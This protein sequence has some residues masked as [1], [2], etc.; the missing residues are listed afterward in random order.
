MLTQHVPEGTKL[1]FPDPIPDVDY[2]FEGWYR[3]T[4]PVDIDTEAASGNYTYT[5]RFK[6]N[7]RVFTIDIYDVR[8]RTTATT[9]NGIT[10]HQ[11]Q[12]DEGDPVDINW[13]VDTEKGPILNAAGEYMSTFDEVPTGDTWYQRVDNTESF[14]TQNYYYRKTF[15][16]ARGGHLRVNNRNVYANT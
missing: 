4:T 8:P 15:Y 10:H 13:F 1:T 6:V 11:Y 2:V 5:A 12:I 9:S 16:A 14:S 3:G 7:R